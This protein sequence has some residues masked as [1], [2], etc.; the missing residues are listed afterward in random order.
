MPARQHPSSSEAPLSSSPTSP[1]P[2]SSLRRLSSLANLQ[3]FNPF[4]SFS[5][6]RSSHGTQNSDDDPY[7]LNTYQQRAQNQQHRQTYLSSSGEPV[8]TLP[9]SNTFSNLPLT[10]NRNHSK[11]PVS[12]KPLGSA[13]LPSRIPTPSMSASAKTRLASATKSILKVGN[14]RGLTRSDTE[15]LLDPHRPQEVPFS[16]IS[17]KE[18]VSLGV[19]TS[20][21]KMMPIQLPE[22]PLYPLDMTTR[23]FNPTR[24]PQTPADQ[25]PKPRPRRDSLQPPTPR[26]LATTALS[27]SLQTPTTVTAK[28]RRRTMLS[29]DV[30]PRHALCDK[31]KQ[32]SLFGSDFQSHQLLTPRAVTTLSPSSCP[33]SSAMAFHPD[34]S[35]NRINLA[36]DIVTSAQSTAYWSGRLMSQFDQRRNE[37]LQARLGEPGLTYPE[38]DLNVCLREL[39]KKCV[40]EAAKLSFAMFKARVRVKAGTL[41]TT[42]SSVETQQVKPTPQAQQDEPSRLLPRPT[43]HCLNIINLQSLMAKSQAQMIRKIL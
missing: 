40:T 28:P 15:P 32:R 33:R 21:T 13:K 23:S 12:M 34:D 42:K 14:R 24:R 43:F 2:R 18:N 27:E 26:P 8:P 41:G 19:S 25:T 35:A 36:G 39:Q 10:R 31:E 11:P 17:H 9:K 3:Q 16:A 29:A 30:V 22:V 5:R 7:L 38:N 37:Q 20:E 1:T 4:N 6:R